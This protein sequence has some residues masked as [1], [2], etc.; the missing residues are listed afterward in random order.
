MAYPQSAP[1]AGGYRREG[2]VQYGVADLMN[3]GGG[4][5]LGMGPSQHAYASWKKS[6]FA[7]S[8]IS[9]PRTTFGHS[10]KKGESTFNL[11]YADPSAPP[12]GASPQLT[13]PQLKPQM[14]VNPI[15]WAGAPP[16]PEYRRPPEQAPTGQYAMPGTSIS[17]AVN[18]NQPKRQPISGTQLEE[19][20]GNLI[21]SG[22]VSTAQCL[23][24]LPPE[25]TENKPPAKPRIPPQMNAIGLTE[26]NHAGY[27]A[28]HPLGQKFTNSFRD[29]YDGL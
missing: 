23:V 29:P 2:K 19:T 3:Q 20:W 8:E 18:R 16:I 7:T 26:P 22:H 11:L 17:D 15:T 4:A 25:F 9:V 6:G 12:G 24:N 28:H 1:P 27:G 21:R 5:A 10:T 13:S 14:P